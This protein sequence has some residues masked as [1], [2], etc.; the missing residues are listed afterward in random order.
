MIEE[1]WKPIE[2]WESTYE[3]SNWGRIKTLERRVGA[4]RGQRLV[5]E[6]I[7]K[8]N[9][10][11][12]GKV[13]VTICDGTSKTFSVDVLVARAFVPNPNKFANV[14][15]RDGD[16]NNCRADNLFWSAS[17]ARLTPKPRKIKGE[18]RSCPNCGKRSFVEQK[19][20]KTYFCCHCRYQGQP[21]ARANTKRMLGVRSDWA[22]GGWTYEALAAKYQISISTAWNW[23][24][25]T[26]PA[27]LNHSKSPH[28]ADKL[29]LG[30]CPPA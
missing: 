17:R 7:R 6:S 12:S 11:P 15:H 25:I 22:A 10:L 26:N 13:S 9:I 2:G 16:Q 29:S 4:N 3:I 21:A 8:N 19:L 14:Q 28:N 24:N 5:K 27:E 1:I 18:N 23:I 30:N 20:T